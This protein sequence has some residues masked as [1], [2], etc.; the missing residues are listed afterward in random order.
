MHK[1]RQGLNGWGNISLENRDYI[2]IK[3]LYHCTPKELETQEVRILDLH[4]KYLMEERKFGELQQ[5]KQEQK[6]QVK[7]QLSK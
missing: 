7:R 3:E 6:Q 2:L 1:F 5:K 4:F